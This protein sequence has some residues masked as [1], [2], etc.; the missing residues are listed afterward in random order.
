MRAV[1]RCAAKDIFGHISAAERREFILKLQAIEVYNEAVHD[2]LAPSDDPEAA[3]ANLKVQ[4][5]PAGPVVESLSEHS[6]ES[7]EHLVKLLKAV[8]T[9]RQVRY[10][11]VLRG[12]NATPHGA[13]RRHMHVGCV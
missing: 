8:E 7:E 3:S 12:R 1:M 6:I 5:G 2:L 10:T 11:Y 13:P 4:D 9:R